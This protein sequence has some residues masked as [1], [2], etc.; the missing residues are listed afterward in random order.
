MI[1]EAKCAPFSLDHDER[2]K[3]ILK[4]EEARNVSIEVTVNLIND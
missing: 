2:W 3:E 4:K 1:L